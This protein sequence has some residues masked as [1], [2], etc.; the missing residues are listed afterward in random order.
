MWQSAVEYP[1][2]WVM[3]EQVMHK[4]VKA[5]HITFNNEKGISVPLSVLCLG[6]VMFVYS[7]EHR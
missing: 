6:Y 1:N 4:I 7:A 5:Y 2:Q 3:K